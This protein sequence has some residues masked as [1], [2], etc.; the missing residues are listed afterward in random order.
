MDITYCW[1]MCK[2]SMPNETKNYGKYAELTLSEMIEFFARMANKLNKNES[3]PLVNKIEWFMDT[4][5]PPLLK[6]ER[7]IVNNDPEEESES[8]RDYGEEFV[9][10]EPDDETFVSEFVP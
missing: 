2:Q 7:V 4:V 1:G 10:S 5:F 8:D 9:L 6:Q 3:L